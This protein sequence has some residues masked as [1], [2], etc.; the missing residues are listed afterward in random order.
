MPEKNNQVVSPAR[1]FSFAPQTRPFAA[2]VY[3]PGK[4]VLHKIR[5]V[6]TTT[7]AMQCDNEE[8]TC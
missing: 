5:T 2:G 8:K 1:P 3:R 6:K 4:F 7:L